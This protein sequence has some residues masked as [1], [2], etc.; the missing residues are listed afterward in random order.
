LNNHGIV[1]DLIVRYFGT[2]TRWLR[3]VFPFL[4]WMPEVR[5]TWKSDI[6]AGF[7]GAVLVLPQGVA[8]AMI[9]GLPPQY[10]LYSAMV[11][12]VVAA[13]FG[14]SR[15]LISGPTTAISIV[16]FSTLVTLAEPGSSQY[17]KLAMLLTLLTGIV[18]ISFGLAR[19]GGL[20]NFISHSVV[21][22]FTA[23]AAVL[24]AA[25]QLKHVFGLH[26][27]NAPE[28]TKNISLII[29]HIHE[30]NPRALTVAALTL[31]I[32]LLILKLKPTWPGMLIGM[33]AGGIL[34]VAFGWQNEGV[35]VVGVLPS[36]LPPFESPEFSMSSLKILASPALAIAML[37]LMEAV[38]IARSIAI[39]SGQRINGNQEFI[40]Q[41]LSNIVGS[42]FSAYACS[43]SFTRTGINYRS[44]AKTAAAAMFAAVFLEAILL[45][46][47]P[48]AAYLPIPS[49]AAVILV[50]AYKLVD[51][52]HIVRIIKLS[53]SDTMILVVTFLSCIFL[54]LE[55]AIYIGTFLSLAIY[56]KK[57]AS[58]GVL[59][60][61]PQPYGHK[62]IADPFMSQCPQMGMVMIK[63]DIYFAATNYIEEQIHNLH[64]R[65]P[66]QNKIV[67]MCSSVN[68]IDLSGVE[69]ILHIVRDYRRNDGDAYFCNVHL[70]VMK[71][72]NMS[73]A[74]E[75]IGA[76][77]LYENQK[78]VLQHIVPNLDLRI[79]ASCPQRA[80]W[81]CDANKS[82]GNKLYGTAENKLFMGDYAALSNQTGSSH[83]VTVDRRLRDVGNSDIQVVLQQRQ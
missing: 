11:P 69:T 66:K 39:H 10:G 16:I 60:C 1:K 79:C 19:L 23:G 63:G 12:A 77:H 24:I 35:K 7:T 52:K 42:F 76:D 83:L 45:F 59:P 44:G 58:P 80:F 74:I 14:S 32:V 40:G 55:F 82:V 72:L 48:Y 26:F 68:H 17:I 3:K 29:Q 54:E 38:S 28:F 30:Y 56:L 4:Q 50:V 49:M 64:S 73:G 51:I 62:H 15:H 9:A 41:G 57:T 46:V 33:V 70:H 37:G 53:R 27:E 61:T 5:H 21:T 22:A 81:E 8:F 65:Y 31:A 71:T 18:Q 36:S 13:L 34:T 67:V 2:D 43:G 78:A 20:I 6:M 25:S 75:E 47:A